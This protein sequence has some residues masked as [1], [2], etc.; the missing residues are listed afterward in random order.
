MSGTIPIGNSLHADAFQTARNSQPSTQ[1]DGGRR[2]ADSSDEKVTSTAGQS[3]AVDTEQAREKEEPVKTPPASP[4]VESLFRQ[5]GFQLSFRV[6]EETKRVIISVIDQESKEVI[7]QV[8]PEEL[9]ELA[10]KLDTI[11]G[12]VVQEK[13]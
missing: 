1:K 6:H 9:L 3:S 12:S 2:I 8:P 7:R 13:V 11:R 10:E 5:S 4:A